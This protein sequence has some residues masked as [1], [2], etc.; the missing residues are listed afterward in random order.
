MGR[1]FPGG[2]EARRP[3]VAHVGDPSAPWSGEADSPIMFGVGSI[4]RTIVKRF[5]FG[6]G[7]LGCWMAASLMLEVPVVEAGECSTGCGAPVATYTAAP[8]RQRG[9]RRLLARARTSSSCAPQASSA[10]AAP[11]SYDA[12]SCTSGGCATGCE[13]PE[14]SSVSDAG[15]GVPVMADSCGAAT[16]VAACGPATRRVRL[17]GNRTSSC[18]APACTTASYVSG[19]GTGGCVAPV[20]GVVSS[21]DCCTVPADA[22]I[23]DSPADTIPEAPAV[24]EPPAEAA[25]TE[26]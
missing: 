26:T 1:S 21:G 4:R 22:V 6:L 3:A 13:V 8:T 19:C 14:W 20:S 23:S 9:G 24:D 15:C 12:P 11:V 18:A 7:M 16:S 17:I 2:T 5:V 10:C 25:A